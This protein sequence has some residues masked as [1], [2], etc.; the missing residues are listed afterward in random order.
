MGL[1]YAILF[2]LADAAQ[3]KSILRTVH[4][5]PKGIVWCGRTSRGSATRVPA[6]TMCWCWPMASGMWAHA[7]AKAG[8][9]ERF[10][11]EMTNTATMTRDSGGIFYE[12]YHSVTGVPDGGWQVG[13]R[14]DSCIDQTWS[15]T[16]YL[17]MVFYGV[18]GM[19]FEPDG[20]RLDPR[21]RRSGAGAAGAGSAIDRPSSTCALKARGNTS[22]A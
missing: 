21:C 7:A 17:R 11:S 18:F 9:I 10:A 2:E 20:V 3:V 14:W 15:A 19:S 12:I 1:A 22:A 13:R 5:Q 6:G 16:G 8:A 4:V